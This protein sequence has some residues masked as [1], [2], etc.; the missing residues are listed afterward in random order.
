MPETRDHVVIVGGG[1]IGVCCA[2]FLAR[3]GAAVTLL[4]REEVGSGA[5]QGNAGCIA[6]GHGPINKPGRL[7]QAI[8][9]MVDSTSPLYV[10]PR[11]DPALTRWL[12]TFHRHCNQEHTEAAMGVLGPLGH[13]SRALFDEMMAE[14]Q[15]ECGYR[16]EGYYEIYRSKPALA[17][18]IVEARRI[19]QH[20]YAPQVLD[21]AVIMEREPALRAGTVGAVYFPEAAS[22]NPHRFVEETARRAARHGARVRTGMEVVELL[23]GGGRVRGVRTREGEVVEGHRV[24][25][26]TGAYSLGL[27]RRLG[28]RIPIQPAKGYHEDQGFED[29]KGQPL[30]ITCMLG[31]RFVFCTPMEGFL[32]FAGTLEFSG[33]NHH[34]RQERLA[35]LSA[36]AREYV[37]GLATGEAQSQWVGLRPCTPDGLPMLGPVP[38]YD[39]LYVANGHAMLGLTLAPVTG[40]L[41]AD[42]VLGDGPSMSLDMLRVGRF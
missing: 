23:T 22:V 26:A 27:V 37:E 36:A 5:S 11:F 33:L 21:G 7:W 42:L 39:G 15:L 16:T 32:R 8:R 6:P 4:E 29:G 30:S 9:W 25:V 19:R 17:G 12:W 34:M 13:A 41:M 2:Y 24:V 10:A 31:E 20:G 3:R 14:E 1:V 28:V 40:R 35:N 18:A 38:G